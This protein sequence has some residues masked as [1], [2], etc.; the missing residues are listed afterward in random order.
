MATLLTNKSVGYSLHFPLSH[1]E[2]EDPDCIFKCN[3][4]VCVG[5]KLSA[6]VKLHSTWDRESRKRSAFFVLI[7]LVKKMEAGLR[8]V[9]GLEYVKSEQKN[10]N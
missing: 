3:A 2:N 1:L 10:R 5:L 4:P 6:Q 7:F 9:Q 8:L